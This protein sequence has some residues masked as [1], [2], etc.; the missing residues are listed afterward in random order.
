MRHRKTTPQLGRS[1]SHRKAMLRNMVT[2]FLRYGKIRT[3][4]AKAKALRP[5]AEKLITA[6]KKDTLH[7]RRRVARLVRDKEVLRKLFNEI[8][9]RYAERPGGYCRIVK[10]PSRAGDNAS[11]AL[12]ELVEAEMKTRTKRK[13]RAYDGPLT[14]AADT[15]AA[16][17]AVAEAADEVATDVA[18]EAADE[19]AEEAADAE[20]AVEAADEGDTTEPAADDSAAE[21]EEEDAPVAEAPSA[22]AGESE[23]KKSE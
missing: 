9:P 21:S 14:A 17:A 8:A 20:Q 1:P 13:K 23:E 18:E 19:V 22:E 10:L 15:A 2:D 12:I 3:T 16:A 4:E 11:M 7:A 5:Y 6:A